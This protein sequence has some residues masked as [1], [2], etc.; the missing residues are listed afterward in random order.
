MKA[1]RFHRTGGPDVL[2]VESVPD[3]VPG[4]G[5]AVVRVRAAALNRLDS[6]LR[7]GASTMPGFSMPHTG[8]FDIAGDVLTVG[9]G[10]DPAMVGRPVVIKARI[11]GPQSRGRLDII[12]IARPGGF[13]EQ[14]LVPLEALVPKP[15][16]LSYAE[17]AAYPCV[18]LTAYYGLALAAGVRPGETVLVHAGGSGAGV[19][20]I[21]IAKLMGAQVIATVGSAAKAEKARSLLGVDQVVNYRT[22]DLAAAIKSF[23][24]GRGVDVVFDPIW[25]NSAAKTID[26]FAYHGRWIVLGMVGGLNA[27]LNAAKLMFREVTLRGIVEFYCADEVF[28]AALNLA[29]QGKLRPLV[30]RVWPLEQLADAYRQLESGEFFGKIVVQP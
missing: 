16:P 25:G 26:C 15:A 14:V 17:A 21:Q 22:D 9:A 2:T 8:G 30:D 28:H 24:H 29:H 6:F 19:A 4:P 13:A 20:A 23:T 3:P 10:G 5:E 18:Y 1:V 12:G 27:E 7:S 11:A